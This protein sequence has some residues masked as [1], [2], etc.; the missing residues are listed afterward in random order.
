MP[1]VVKTL[2]SAVLVLGWSVI[3]LADPIV[4]IH[5]GRRVSASAFAQDVDPFTGE[6]GFRASATRERVQGDALF[7]AANVHVNAANVFPQ[8][9]LISDISDPSHMSGFGAAFTQIDVLGSGPGDPFTFRLFDA[10]AQSDVTFA[11]DFRLASPFNFVFTS[12]SLHGDFARA[13]LVGAGSVFF[14]VGGV[15]PGSTFT[16]TGQLSPGEY[17]LLVEETSIF[18]LGS[19][20]LA[21]GALRF[22]VGADFWRVSHFPATC[23]LSR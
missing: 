14:D 4:I 2:I 22:V 16:Q 12:P 23:A 17:S 1:A 10:Q 9:F 5:D 8:A 3:A 13:S 11:V 7:V 19:G 21:T 15:G 20:T 18:A 6:P